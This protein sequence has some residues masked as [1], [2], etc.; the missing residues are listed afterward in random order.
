MTVRRHLFF[1]SSLL[2]VSI[3]ALGGNV[4][5]KTTPALSNS[6]CPVMKGER[7][8]AKFSVNYRGETIYL[9]CKSCIRKFNKNPERYWAVLTEKSL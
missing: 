6:L 5:A 9:C 7:S 4:A 8:K 3:I 2:W 1:L